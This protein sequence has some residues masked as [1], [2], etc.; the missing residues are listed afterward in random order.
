MITKLS[1]VESCLQ[2]QLNEYIL[3]TPYPNQERLEQIHHNLCHSEVFRLNIC[4][5]MKLF[6][7]G[8]L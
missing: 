3:I 2:F 1:G 8:E 7:V 4:W 5:L 6:K